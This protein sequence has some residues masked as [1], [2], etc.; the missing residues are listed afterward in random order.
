MT[1]DL[2]GCICLFDGECSRNCRTDE[3]TPYLPDSD[4]TIFEIICDEE[5]DDVSKIACRRMEQEERDRPDQDIVGAEAWSNRRLRLW[6]KPNDI[7]PHDSAAPEK[8]RSMPSEYSDDDDEDDW[9]LSKNRGTF[10]L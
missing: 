1:P 6:I 3:K 4:A 5:M 8:K 7:K 2:L 9:F 10:V